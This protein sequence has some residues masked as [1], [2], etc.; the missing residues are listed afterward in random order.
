MIII[1]I[2]LSVLIG[3]T[4]LHFVAPRFNIYEKVG[5]SFILG[6][7]F[8][9]F[10]LFL[11][12]IV[13]LEINL[14]SVLGISLLLILFFTYFNFKRDKKLLKIIFREAD[15]VKITFAWV[16]LLGLLSYL[17]YGAAVK[18]LF[19][20]IAEYDSMTGYNLMGKMIASE[21]TFKVSIFEYPFAT[22]Y[23]IAR[24][25]YPPLVASG[26]AYFYI[27]GADNAKIYILCLFVSF[28]IA[29]YGLLKNRLSDTIAIFITLLMMVTPEFFSHVSLGLTNLPNAIYTSLSFICFYYW[30]QNRSNSYFIVSLILMAGSMWSRSDSI[31]FVAGYG[32]LFLI[33]FVKTREW[34]KPLIYLSS[35]FAMFMI[36][37]LFIKVNV[38]ANS[39]DFFVKSLF[40]DSNKFTQI[41]SKSFDLMLGS[42]TLYGITF[43][44]FV[45]F[46]ALNIVPIVLTA[47]RLVIFILSTWLLYTLL[48]YQIDYGFAGSIEAYLNASYKRG[49]FNF[50]P[51]AWFFIAVSPLSEKWLTKLN[52]WLYQ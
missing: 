14:I 19:W 5:L 52:N 10:V 45:I 48:Y 39:S 27:F 32:L 35:C 21:G 29:F 8:Q 49:L 31:V 51:L 2:I 9:W 16:V 17:M 13:G 50:I 7:F 11:L 20:P 4:F 37:N 23:E 3:F 24:F 40:W 41:F 38:G 42:G 36:W 25:I 28:I 26:L 33:E 30:L 22:A 34:I 12:N 6:I 47:N 44:A 18:C 15:Q 43:Y 1:G 46:I